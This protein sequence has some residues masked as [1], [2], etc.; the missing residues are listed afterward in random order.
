M[1]ATLYFSGAFVHDV[2][3]HNSALTSVEVAG[4]DVTWYGYVTQISDATNSWAC[5]VLLSQE[6]KSDTKAWPAG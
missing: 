5:V 3:Q 6:P 2:C 4:H 1:P